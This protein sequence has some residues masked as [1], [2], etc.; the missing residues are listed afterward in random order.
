MIG[1]VRCYCGVNC[2]VVSGT[3]SGTAVRVA[4]I[5]GVA[6]WIIGRGSRINHLW[7]RIGGSVATIIDYAGNHVDNYR[8]GIGAS[9]GVKARFGTEVNIAR[10]NWIRRVYA[11]STRD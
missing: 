10:C 11:F 9:S 5:A 8:T 4:R 2:A 7:K 3:V 1:R 6:C